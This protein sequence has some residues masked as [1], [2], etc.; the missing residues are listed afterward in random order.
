LQ[1]FGGDDESSLSNNGLRLTC[2]SFCYSIAF[3]VSLL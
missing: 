1:V 3:D 2:I